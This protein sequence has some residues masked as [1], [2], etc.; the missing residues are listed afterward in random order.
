MRGNRATKLIALFFYI[1]VRIMRKILGYSVLLLLPVLLVLLYYNFY[2]VSGDQWSIQ[3]QFYKITGWLC[4]GCGGQRAFYSLLHGEFLHALRCN[5]LITILLPMLLVCYFILGRIYIVRDRS[6][7][8][9]PN[10]SPWHAYAVLALMLLFFV[11]RNISV[12]PFT[13]LSPL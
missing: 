1:D 13:L 5:A 6:V 7:K 11:L 3:C 9:L 10:L 8:R 4:P 12:F 2:A